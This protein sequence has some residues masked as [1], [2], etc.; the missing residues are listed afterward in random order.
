MD[1]LAAY[2]TMGGYGGFIW[3]AYGVTALV[4][5]GLVVSTWR[6]LKA[7]EK[8]LKILQ[9]MSPG[10]RGRSRGAADEGAGQ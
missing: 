3:S 7:R 1:T 5:A 9:E 6:S 8:E 2:M 10:R 4:M